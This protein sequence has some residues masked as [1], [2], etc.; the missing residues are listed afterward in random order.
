M[1]RVISAIWNRPNRRFPPTLISL[2]NSKSNR[3]PT[4]GQNIRLIQSERKYIRQ[5]YFTNKIP[6][7]KSACIVNS[8]RFSIIVSPTLS[9]LAQILILPFTI[10]LPIHKREAL[11]L[12]PLFNFDESTPLSPSTITTFEIKIFPPPQ[13]LS[14]IRLDELSATNA[15]KRVIEKSLRIATIWLPVAGG[16]RAR[17]C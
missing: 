9:S 1:Y 11:A 6:L 12:L 3:T 17:G 14:R 4:R 5:I 15:N 8:S 13:H 16:L 10:R 2:N 7:R